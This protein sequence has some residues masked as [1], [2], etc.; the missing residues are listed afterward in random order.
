MA[1][2]TPWSVKG[3]SDETRDVA[4]RAAFETDST[5]GHWVD[6][7]ILEYAVYEGGDSNADA[8]TEPNVDSIAVIEAALLPLGRSVESLAAKLVAAERSAKGAKPKA[9]LAKEPPQSDLDASGSRESEQPPEAPDGK[10]SPGDTGNMDGMVG[11]GG[12]GGSM[13]PPLASDLAGGSSWGDEVDAQPAQSKGLEADAPTQSDPTPSQDDT[14]S[15][16]PML[17]LDELIRSEEAK[18]S[19][20]VDISSEALDPLVDKGPF[21]RE[22]LQNEEDEDLLDLDLEWEAK[23]RAAESEQRSLDDPDEASL[24]AEA[25]DLDAEWSAHQRAAERERNARDDQDASDFPQDFDARPKSR[26]E[27]RIEGRLNG[28][29]PDELRAPPEGEDLLDDDFASPDGDRFGDPSQE[30]GL[31]DDDLSDEDRE[32]ILAAERAFED[33]ERRREEEPLSDG[34]LSDGS[35]SNDQDIRD[36]DG[37]FPDDATPFSRADLQ[38]NAPRRSRFRALKIAATLALLLGGGAAA[39]VVTGAAEPLLAYGREHYPEPTK[40]VERVIQSAQGAV[41]ELVAEIGSVTGSEEGESAAESDVAA[42]PAQSAQD[43]T[44]PAETAESEPLQADATAVDAN[45]GSLESGSGEAKPSTEVRVGEDV[46]GS[47]SRE[48]DTAVQAQSTVPAEVLSSG[49]ATVALAVDSTSETAEASVPAAVNEDKTTAEPAAAPDNTA[50]SA[51]TSDELPKPRPAVEVSQAGP[52]VTAPDLAPT[53]VRPVTETPVS[54]PAVE[55]AQS[56]QGLPADSSQD[57]VRDAASR[58]P[59]PAPDPAGEADEQLVASVPPAP[60]PLPQ[61]SGDAGLSS[62]TP[63]ADPKR[64]VAWTERRARDG[65]RTAQHNLAIFYAKGDGVD[66][67]YTKAAYWFREAAIQG[68]PNAQYNLGVL[69]ENGWGVETSDV[70][71]LLWYHSAAEAGHAKAQ[72]NLGIFYFEGRGNPVNFTE[73]RRWFERAGVSD[74]A[75]G[76]YNLA[77][78]EE[79]GLGAPP[80]R[81]AAIARYGQAALGGYQDARSELTRLIGE[82]DL[83]SVTRVGKAEIAFV[84]SYLKAAGY[85]IGAPDGIFGER[86]REALVSYQQQN[87]LQPTGVIDRALL[88]TFLQRVAEG[89]SQS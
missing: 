11:M 64:L 16:P 79:E 56:D 30:P 84:Q 23:Q 60:P 71:S 47:E 3:I 44:I 61:S 50:S 86:T 68:V 67:D 27:G 51:L 58:N 59:V 63:P 24:D 76:F 81:S 49:E 33:F 73:A 18:G 5:I 36:L 31:R 70:R 77:R 53:P 15:L 82:S 48:A 40:A 13:W 52:T 22:D 87:S 35:H 80:D 34:P 62:D 38:D 10:S 74:Q 2:S 37:H 32:D 88:A 57:A 28:S 21:E 4:K 46:A 12:F 55:A 20:D 6:A 14:D 42:A 78:M 19:D 72:Y 7:A 29:F 39:A 8:P 25:L 9:G 75:G 26:L 69:Y 45:E 43:L 41:E 89:R 66:Q 54:P 17:D 85:G 65:D 83:G 1:K